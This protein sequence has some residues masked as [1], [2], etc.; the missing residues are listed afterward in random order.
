MAESKA[1]NPQ[2]LAD[3]LQRQNQLET[4]RRELV[5]VLFNRRGLARVRAISNEDWQRAMER[6][7]NPNL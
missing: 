6:D 2:D 5:K 4:A 7:A 3:D 1:K